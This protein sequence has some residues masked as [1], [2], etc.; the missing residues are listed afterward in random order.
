MDQFIALNETF[1]G[2]YCCLLQ[3]Q[4]MNKLSGFS[5]NKKKTSI[6]FNG[7]ALLI[8]FLHSIFP[9]QHKAFTQEDPGFYAPMQSNFLQ[10][11]FSAN[12]GAH[13]LEDIMQSTD[14]DFQNLV[15]PCSGTEIIFSVS[16]QTTQTSMLS[17][18]KTNSSIHIQTQL[19]A[20]PKSA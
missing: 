18:E 7:L 11:I 8:L 10:K 16:G 17:I 20:P 3:M 6:L 14:F 13:H 4:F 2:E 15:A 5:D 19:R 9:H 12:P 1:A